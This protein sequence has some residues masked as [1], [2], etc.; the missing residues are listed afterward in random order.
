MTLYR[1]KPTD[2]EAL[3]FDSTK[4]RHEWPQGVEPERCYCED[5]PKAKTR[6]PNHG[7]KGQRYRIFKSFNYDLNIKSGD[8]VVYYPNDRIDV[9][10]DSNFQA[11]FDLHPFP[12]CPK[13]KKERTV[14]ACCDYERARRE[15]R[16][17]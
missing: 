1:S 9:F 2:V 8:W 11:C 4:P 15:P 17:C 12:N 6:C 13:C 3:R 14:E 16:S 10:T 5:V 7:G